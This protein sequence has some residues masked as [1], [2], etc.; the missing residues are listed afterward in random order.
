MLK[1]KTRATHIVEQ[2]PLSKSAT[3][4]SSRRKTV[5]EIFF[6]KQPDSESSFV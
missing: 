2:P 3:D 1:K 5:F 4:N 6:F